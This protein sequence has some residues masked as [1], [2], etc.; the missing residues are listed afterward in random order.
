MINIKCLNR[1]HPDDKEQNA[2]HNQILKVHLGAAG[3][4]IVAY[5]LTFFH[6]MFKHCT[7]NSRPS[8]K[9][10]NRT[11]LQHSFYTH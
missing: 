4:T 11:K 9:Q 2:N 7:E 5:L 6:F 1:I 10:I 8:C 3:G